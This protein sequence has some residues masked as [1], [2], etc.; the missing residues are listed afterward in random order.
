MVKNLA[1]LHYLL[2]DKMLKGQI[3]LVYIDPPFATGGNFTITANRAS[4]ISSPRDGDLAYSDKITGEDFL[5]FLRPRLLI[6]R[7]LMSERGSIYLHIDYKMGHYVKL[8]MD[9]I[10]GIENFRNDITRIKCN[11]KNFNRIGYSC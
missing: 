10:F 2:E 7:E 5:D 9:E 1:V 3:D 6:L 4:T 11:P 8:L